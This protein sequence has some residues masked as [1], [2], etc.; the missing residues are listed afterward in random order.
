MLEDEVSDGGAGGELDPMGD[1]SGDTAMSP[2]LKVISLPPS[3]PGGTDLIGLVGK[4]VG[5]A[6]V[7]PVLG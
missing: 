4:G 7:P 6:R 5:R 1:A 3:R 2:G